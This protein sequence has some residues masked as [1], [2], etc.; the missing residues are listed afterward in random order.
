MIDLH[1]YLE[2][3]GYS[4]IS[5]SDFHLSFDYDQKIKVDII[6]NYLKNQLRFIFYNKLKD[7]SERTN[8]IILENNWGENDIDNI[9]N[10]IY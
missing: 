2:S 7:E 5:E 6:I 10:T 9:L 8:I 1:A 4:I 3:K